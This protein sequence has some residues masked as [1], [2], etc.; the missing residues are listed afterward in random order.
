M[1]REDNQLMMNEVIN[2]KQKIKIMMILIH[3]N[4]AD[5]IL[6]KEKI[7]QKIKMNQKNFQEFQ[8]LQQQ[9]IGNYQKSFRD[10]FKIMLEIQKMHLVNGEEQMR[11]LQQ[12]ISEMV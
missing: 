5:Q 2:I 4:Q 11:N 6:K 10:K 9:T 12:L 7:Q 8:K 3:K 1:L